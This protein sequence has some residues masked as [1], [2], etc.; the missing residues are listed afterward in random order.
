MAVQSVGRLAFT[1]ISDGK[2]LNFVLVPN[3]SSQVKSKDPVSY[4]PNFGSS[5]LEITPILTISGNGGENMVKGTCTWFY[6]TTAT[7]NFTQVTSGQD[8]FTVKTSS[9]DHFKLV[10]NKNLS[11][12]SLVIMCRYNYTDPDTGLSLVVETIRTITQTE[13]AGTTIMAY[14]YEGFT[15]FSTKA[16]QSQSKT[17]SGDMIRGGS[18]DQT[19]V[20]Y[21]WSIT[22][23]NGVERAIV[24]GSGWD[25]SGLPAGTFSGWNTRQLTL[26]NAA[27]LNFATVKLTCKDTDTASSTYNKTVYAVATVM[28]ATDPYEVDLGKEQ[29]IIKSNTLGNKMTAT[30]LQGGK[31]W[32]V[33]DYNNKKLVLYRETAAGAKDSTWAPPASDFPGWSVANGEVSR[34]YNS[35][36]GLATE[37]NRTVSIKFDHMLAG[38]RTYFCVALDF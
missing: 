24:T 34:T 5:N 23:K 32:E 27:V 4:T 35:T 2:T 29:T 18:A 25:G 16:G 21:Q 20:N 13:N 11:T 6:K 26:T 37:A 30:V 22:D 9:A 3:Y 15:V 1:K 38:V 17:I 14:I 12:P 10:Y 33:S 31:E 28:D 8:G 7:A 36:A 19:N